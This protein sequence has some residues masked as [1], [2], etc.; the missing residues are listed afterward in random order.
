MADFFFFGTLC[1]APLLAEVLGRKPDSLPATLQGYAGFW[2]KG[3]AFPLLLAQDGG[4]TAGVL[5]RG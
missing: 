5:S 1:H 4:V 3:R 2:A